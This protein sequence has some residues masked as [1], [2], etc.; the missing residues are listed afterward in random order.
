M[1]RRLVLL[2]GLLV[3]VGAVSSCITEGRSKREPIPSLWPEEGAPEVLLRLADDL[4]ACQASTGRLPD[5]LAK[6]DHAGIASGG[7]YAGRAYAY[8]PTGIGVL[9]E[10]WHIFVADDRIR[11]ADRV[12]CVVRPPIRLAGSPALRVVL[13]PVIELREAAATAGGGR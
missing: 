7:P 8:H 6:L 1:R 3:C 10:G 9:R 2:L 12:W 5:S 13:V 11:E 4:A